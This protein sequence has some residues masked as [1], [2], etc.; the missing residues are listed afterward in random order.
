MLLTTEPFKGNLTVPYFPPNNPERVKFSRN[1]TL[2]N[3]FL[4]SWDQFV[5][6]VDT[7]SWENAHETNH[8]QETQQECV[9]TIL[10]VILLIQLLIKLETTAV[11]TLKSHAVR[12]LPWLQ[13]IAVHNQQGAKGGKF[14]LLN[15]WQKTQQLLLGLHNRLLFTYWNKISALK[16][17][18]DCLQHLSN[19]L[20]V[21]CSF[22]IKRTLALK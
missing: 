16:E 19:D 13:K 8:K 18:P 7:T 17:A 11:S 20:C 1:F 3:R 14:P 15:Y 21:P 2:I 22:K 6:S 12:I 10:T 5:S 9:Q 4:N